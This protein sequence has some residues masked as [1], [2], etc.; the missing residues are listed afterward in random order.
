MTIAVSILGLAFL[1]LVHELG[2]FGV[3][4]ALRMRP[5]R[6]YLGFPPAVWKTT[7]NGIEY[8]VG[9]IPLGGFVKIPG[10]HRP[11]PAD[12]DV[13]LGRAVEDDP[14]LTGPSARLR[15]ALAASDHDT[16]RG[17]VAQLRTDLPDRQL[18]DPAR[19]AAD[20]GLEDL[21]D[22]L[23]PDA[24]WRAATWKRVA[25]IAAGP[26]ANIL[27]AL[28]LFT[29]LFM[30]SAGQATTKVESVRAGSPAASA[31]LQP[32][33]R[34]VSIDGQPAAP[35]HIASLVGASGGKPIVVVVERRGQAV[36]L[37]ATAPQLSDG[38]YR[39]GFVLAGEGLSLPAAARE[40]L[41]LTG[42][43][44]GQVVAS[45]GH[46]VTGSGR[47]EISSPVGIVQGSSDAAKQGTESFLVVLGLLSLSIAL[48]NLLPLL[49]LDGGH[50]V[51]AVAEGL[52]GRAV[53]REVYERVSFV[54]IGLVLLLFFIGLTN[55][56]GRLS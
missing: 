3:S 17:V 7:R 5:R 6:F 23:G 13:A 48:L 21:A 39:L 11:A 32:G 36:T 31:G 50:I 37:P 46:L 1:I 43:V 44:T 26:G 40:S 2:H 16:A 42:E 54:G 34:V 24:Y 15:N 9:A 4:L 25:V 28:V 51:F 53:A 10:M 12:V 18:S 14:G 30:T 35:E 29:G 19:R 33:D 49:P 20:K 56:V 47:N 38:A 41:S 22:A 27:L 45:L 52:R 8:G 55:D